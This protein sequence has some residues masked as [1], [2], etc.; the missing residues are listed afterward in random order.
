M[1]DPIRPALAGEAVAAL[2]AI[3][4]DPPAGFELL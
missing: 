4:L 1:P 3:G 2:R